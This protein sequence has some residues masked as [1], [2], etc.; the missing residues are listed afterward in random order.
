MRKKIIQSEE[1]KP[2]TLP[3]DRIP[4]TADRVNNV[5]Q[6]EEALYKSGVTRYKTY[7]VINELLSA[8]RIETTY[9]Q[10]GEEIKTEVPDLEKRKQGAELALRAFGDSKESVAI[11]TQVN[12][13]FKAES[14]LSEIK[15]AKEKTNGKE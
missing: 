4:E 11:N 10:D 8:M 15:L 6:K 14:I 2:K 13:I 7:K 12:N 1:I 9:T 5:T 3:V